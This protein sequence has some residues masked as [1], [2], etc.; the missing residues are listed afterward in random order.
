MTGARWAKATPPKN[1][2]R[3]VYEK[4]LFFSYN[5]LAL[6]RKWAIVLCTGQK[7]ELT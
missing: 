7:I 3:R 6:F 1:Q 2:M 5:L 4:D